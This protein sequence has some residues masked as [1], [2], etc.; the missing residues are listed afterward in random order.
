MSLFYCVRE[1]SPLLSDGACQS[2][3]PSRGGDGFLPPKEVRE[4]DSDRQNER[5]GRQNLDDPDDSEQ[6]IDLSVGQR[7]CGKR[8]EERQSY[9]Y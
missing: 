1:Y 8:C 6:A 5:R 2:A 9:R 3:H 4:A 7:N